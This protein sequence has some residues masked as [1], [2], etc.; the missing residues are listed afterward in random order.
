[1]GFLEIAAFRSRRGPIAGLLVAALAAAATGCGS[2]SAPSSSS[3]TTAV[4]Q[5]LKVTLTDKGCSPK[6]LTAKSG[7]ITFV[8]VNG[9]TKKV[10]ELEL[11]KPNGVVLGE[12]EDVVGNRS[13]SFSLSLGPGHYVLICPLV[14]L[15]GGNGTLVV[16]GKPLSGG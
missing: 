14:P 15:G 5:V 2:G 6:K 10:T 12:K 11:S 1:V 8:V 13:R 4:R 16:T 9:G 3:T 7:P